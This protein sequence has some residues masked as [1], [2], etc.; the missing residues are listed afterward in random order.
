MTFNS[1]VIAQNEDIALRYAVKFFDANKC[2]PDVGENNVFDWRGPCH[3]EDGNSVNIDLT[4]G[5]HT[6]GGHVKYI[7]PQ[8]YSA[9]I[10][11]WSLYENKNAFEFTDMTEKSIS[12]LKRF[13]DLL[14]KAY[15]SDGNF[16]YQIGLEGIDDVYW[17]A[18]EEQDSPRPV[19]VI[20]QDNPGSDVLGQASAALSL[21]Y[22]NYKD[23][24]SAYAQK[25][26]DT[27]K[28]LYKMGKEN[29]G[30]YPVKEKY[31]SHSYYDDL[32]WAAVWL[33][34]AEREESY[35]K[36]AVKYSIQQDLRGNDPLEHKTTMYW[37]DVYLPTF[38]K[39]MDYTRNTRY[40]NAVEQNLNH[41][42][43]EI[44]ETPGGLKYLKKNGVLMY[45]AS[46]SMIALMYSKR[47]GTSKYIEFAKSQINYILGE[48]PFYMSYLIGFGGRFPDNPYHKAAN[49][50]ELTDK[51]KIKGPAENLLKGAL[52]NGPD[53]EDR[54]IN[55]GNSNRVALEYNASFVGAVSTLIN[56]NLINGIYE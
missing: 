33:Y 27:A 13:T 36:D 6:D 25:C 50:K 54:Y 22:L 3:I 15:T 37:D 47:T 9:S 23:I 48:N 31:K 20:N 26:L 56:N 1:V 51:G 10:L 52:V 39:L 21:M 14:L 42:Q 30:P 40:R 5:Y 35:L 2:G 32:A 41:W 19:K 12:I 11:G 45:A 4:G 28:V 8:A 49:G 7:L 16:Y 53:I 46:E 34:S 55:D 29:K 18:P 43:N 17:G 24:D 38:I 44:K